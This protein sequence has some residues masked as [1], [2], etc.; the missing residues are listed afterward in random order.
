MQ[1]KKTTT[2][3]IVAGLSLLNLAFMLFLPC[4]SIGIGQIA[5]LGIMRAFFMFGTTGALIGI[6]MLAGI[7]AIA[8]ALI[9]ALIPSVSAKS[10]GITGCAGS[11]GSAGVLLALLIWLSSTT[12]NLSMGFMSLVGIDFSIAG[13]CILVVFLVVLGVFSAMLCRPEYRYTPGH[14]PPPPMPPTPPTPYPPYTPPSGGRILGRSG[15]C[16]GAAFPLSGS[17]KV[18]MGRDWRVCNIVIEHNNIDV[19]RQHCAVRYQGNGYLVTD[20]SKNGT[21][22]SH[23]ASNVHHQALPKNIETLVPKGTTIELGKKGNIFYL[24]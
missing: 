1:L 6:V 14:V 20:Y 4:C 11:F 24:E 22:W 16:N 10:A 18:L 9:L 17:A 8:A 2:R 7:L 23:P 13:S 5:Y 12:G 3:Y 15:S 21:Y 19:S